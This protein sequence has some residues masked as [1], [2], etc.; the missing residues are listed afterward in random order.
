MFSTD[1]GDHGA[2][3]DD[4][5]QHGFVWANVNHAN[6]FAPGSPLCWSDMN[7]NGIVNVADLFMLLGG[8][9]M[10][11]DPGVLPTWAR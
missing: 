11:I 3:W 5:A 1:P 6:D 2:F 9:T 7:D 10:S 8:V 4:V